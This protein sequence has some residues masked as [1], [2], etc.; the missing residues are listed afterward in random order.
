MNITLTQNTKV[1]EGL[2]PNFAGA[3]VVTTP[4][5]LK[6]VHR[7]WV[8][9]NY[10]D[11]GTGCLVA[12]GRATGVAFAD[13]VVLVNPIKI[14]YNGNTAASD[15]LVRQPDAVNFLLDD[16]GTNQLLVL[17]I[18]P[19]TLGL[20]ANNVQY[21]CLAVDLGLGLAAAASVTYIADI[22]YPQA[23][24]PSIIQD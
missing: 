11:G 3:P 7:L 21:D 14:W 12:P 17:D 15:T 9:I 24:P 6:Y 18:D 23:T 20:N 22:R 19:V 10:I 5:S 13:G 4:I 8:V 16:S 1:V 2:A